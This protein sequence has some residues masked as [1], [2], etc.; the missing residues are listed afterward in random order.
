VKRILLTALLAAGMLAP[1]VPAVPAVPADTAVTY[2]DL[3][4]AFD[5]AGTRPADAPASADL[6]GSGHSRRS[7]KGG[8]DNSHW[9]PLDGKTYRLP[10]QKGGKVFSAA[11]L[12]PGESVTIDGQGYGNGPCG[13][14]ELLQ[15]LK[16]GNS[17]LAQ[18]TVNGD[19]QIATVKEIY[20]P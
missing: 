9:V 19:D 13:Q 10:L 3:A 17:I 8:P 15:H 14:N 1:A 2:P 4:S 5:N 18:I 12:C 16:D 20:H 6:D 7:Q 11:T